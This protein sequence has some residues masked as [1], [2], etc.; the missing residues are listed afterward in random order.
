MAS[1]TGLH[2]R[3]SSCRNCAVHT[4]ARVRILVGTR[5]AYDAVDV[6]TL[7]VAVALIRGLS[8]LHRVVVAISF[9]AIVVVWW[10]C[11]DDCLCSLV[12]VVVVVD[13]WWCGQG[14]VRFCTCAFGSR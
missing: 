9:I 6:Q 7:P 8:L 12:F 14:A 10:L 1:M 4:E 13:S 3:L 2:N 5:L 11:C